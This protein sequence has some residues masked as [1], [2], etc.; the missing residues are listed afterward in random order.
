MYARINLSK[1][2]NTKIFLYVVV[3]EVPKA[4]HPDICSNKNTNC[5]VYLCCSKVMIHQKQDLEKT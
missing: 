4:R 1:S 3:R 2:S 5:I